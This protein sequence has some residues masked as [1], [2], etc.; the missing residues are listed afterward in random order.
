MS[1]SKEERSPEAGGAHTDL[2]AVRAPPFASGVGVVVPVP[3]S[4]PQAK[5]RMRPEMSHRPRRSKVTV[6]DTRPVR[7]AESSRVQGNEARPAPDG[8]VVIDLPIVA[9]ALEPTLLL[10]PYTVYGEFASGGMASVHLARRTEEGRAPGVVA[11]KRLHPHLLRDQ[12]F[13]TM[14]LDEARI[15]SRIDHPNVVRVIDVVRADRELLLVMDYVHG[16]SLHEL[17]RAATKR[18]MPI[19]IAV[20]VRIAVDVLQGLHAAHGAMGED[21]RPLELVHRDVSPH[22]VLVGV[23]GTARLTDFGVAKAVGRLQSTRD[24]GIKGKLAYMPPEQLS[25]GHVDARTDV[26]ATAVMLWEAI[27]GRPLFPAVTEAELYTLV[28]MGNIVPLRTIAPN[29]PRALDDAIMRAL[30]RDPGRRPPSAEAFAEALADVIAP[31]D[32]A[33][34]AACVNGLASEALSQRAALVVQVVGPPAEPVRR[35]R[36]GGKFAALGGLAGLVT[37]AF[38]LLVVRGFS[39]SS[40][41]TLHAERPMPTLLTTEPPMV[42]TVRPTISVAMADASTLV[43]TDPPTVSTVRPA[44]AVAPASAATVAPRARAVRRGDRIPPKPNCDPPFSIDAHGVQ[45]FRPECAQ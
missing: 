25:G 26:Y 31:A 39:P 18:S 8:R 11:I 10:G 27:A 36:S 16:A 41:A 30:A 19:P 38:A 35:R 21:G 33:A 32:P 20:S 1:S 2:T 29:T 12:T 17:V 45:R 5:G 6:S 9:P 3:V 28:M 42:T 13:V 34:V 14:L 43:V 15:A 40:A 4:G 7:L 24:G 23:D 22:N 44:M 37:L